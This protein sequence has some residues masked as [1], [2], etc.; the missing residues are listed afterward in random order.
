VTG[1]NHIVECPNC[2]RRN[3][4]RPAACVSWR[5]SRPRSRVQIAIHTH[6]NAAQSVTPLVAQAARAMLDAGVRDVR[7]RRTATGPGRRTLIA[8]PPW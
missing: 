8:D 5:T 4:L 7:N 6:V 2:R 3:R 1:H